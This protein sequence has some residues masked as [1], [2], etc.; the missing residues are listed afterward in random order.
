MKAVKGEKKEVLH[1]QEKLRIQVKLAKA[2]NEDWSYK[3]MSEA[4]EIT[5]QAFYNWLHGYYELSGKKEMLL[6]SLISDLLE[7]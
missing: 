4:I 2:L 5:P 6:R 1:S 7:M 3:Q